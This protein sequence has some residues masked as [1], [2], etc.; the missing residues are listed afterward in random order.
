MAEWCED[1]A[2]ATIVLATHDYINACRNYYKYMKRAEKSRENP[3]ILI[4]KP[5]ENEK[6]FKARQAR[7]SLK[8]YENKVEEYAVVVKSLRD[9]FCG[10]WFRQLTSVDGSVVLERLD[11]QLEK[12][13][14]KIW[15]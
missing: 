3:E 1:L 7:H 13:G 14:H 4:K 11:K 8:T 15:D 6:S 5:N 10:A 9:F 2:N 12:E